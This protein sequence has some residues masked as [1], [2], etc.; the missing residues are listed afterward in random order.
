[1]DRTVKSVV[2]MRSGT[3]ID[4]SM[5]KGLERVCEGT[6]TE[7]TT[8]SVVPRTYHCMAGPETTAG[9]I[10]ATFQTEASQSRQEVG[11]SV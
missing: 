5:Y 9:K 7:E 6:D 3:Y 10:T 11:R 2:E 8:Q 1:M 4:V